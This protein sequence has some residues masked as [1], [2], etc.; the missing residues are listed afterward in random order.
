MII[1]RAENNRHIILF[2]M[3]ADLSGYQPHTHVEDFAATHHQHY[4]PP[5]VPIPSHIH[6]SSVPG[7]SNDEKN[8]IIVQ[9]Q[10][11]HFF[12]A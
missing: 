4:A 10:V 5:L 8:D 7:L 9:L 11:R 1:R 12:D 2:P 3:C 6:H